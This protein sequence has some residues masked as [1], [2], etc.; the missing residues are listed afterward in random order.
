MSTGGGEAVGAPR[1][2][3]GPTISLRPLFHSPGALHL[4]PMSDLRA[5]LDTA[6]GQYRIESQVGEGG[7]LYLGM[8]RV[9]AG[10]ELAPALAVRWAPVPLWAYAVIPLALSLCA[11]W[12][13]AR[14]YRRAQ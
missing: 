8:L 10:P 14:R 6:L 13:L 4:E 2:V 5:R 9:Y 3:A 12:L 7:W 11:L 1:R